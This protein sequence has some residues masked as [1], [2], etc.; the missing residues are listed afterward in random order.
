MILELTLTG[1]FRFGSYIVVLGERVQ[2]NIVVKCC[3]CGDYEGG[4][5]DECEGG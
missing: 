5:Q 3:K 2:D 1:M 4:V